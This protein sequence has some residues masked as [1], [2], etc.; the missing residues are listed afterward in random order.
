VDEAVR[1][2][3]PLP[4]TITSTSFTT[5]ASTAS[6]YAP[7]SASTPS[8]RYEAKAEGG[9]EGT[10]L[11]RFQQPVRLRGGRGAELYV[12]VHQHAAQEAGVGDDYFDDDLDL[13]RSAPALR[14]P[15]L[16][17][18]AGP[19]YASP[20]P[21]LTHSPS[22]RESIEREMRRGDVPVRSPGLTPMETYNL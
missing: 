12:R 20:T 13:D 18:L 21:L 1:C 10:T 8:T 9:S 2:I 5:A 14:S 11:L 15:Y 19:A 6:I 16:A 3:P 22:V 4:N 17:T 7:S